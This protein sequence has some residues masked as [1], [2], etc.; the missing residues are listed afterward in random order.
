MKGYREAFYPPPPRSPSPT[1]LSPLPTSP[2]SALPA[3][4]DETGNISDDQGLSGAQRNGAARPSARRLFEPG[5]EDGMDDGP[6]FDEL[7]AMEEMEREQGGGSDLVRAPAPAQDA[8]ED[9][10][11][12]LY[13]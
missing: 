1:G 11:E 2:P 5:P 3:T 12:G 7:L 9:E 8:E 13:D 6:D 4:N 10:W